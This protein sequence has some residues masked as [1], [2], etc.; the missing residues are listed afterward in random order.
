VF[1]AVVGA[2]GASGVAGGAT[3]SAAGVVAGAGSGHAGAG[4][5]AAFA[6]QPNGSLN[7]S[8]QKDQQRGCGCPAEAGRHAERTNETAMIVN[9]TNF[10]MVLLQ[11][12]TNMPTISA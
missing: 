12:E 1:C 2:G 11:G 6:L 7:S 10:N 5:A 8:L 9:G 4:A 3:G